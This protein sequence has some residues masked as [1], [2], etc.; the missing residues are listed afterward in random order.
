MQTTGG[1]LLAAK[2]FKAS[3]VSCGINTPQGERK[4]LVVVAADAPSSAAGVFTTNKVQAAP[5]VLSKAHVANGMAQAIVVNSGNAN[6][7]NGDAGIRDARAMVDAVADDLGI[8]SE[9]VLIAST[10]VIG[11]PMPMDCIQAGIQEATA[12]I[13]AGGGADAAE[14]IMTTDTVP[15]SHAIQADIEGYTV[16]IGGISKGAGMICPNMA[17]MIAVITTDAAIAPGVLKTALRTAVG[18]S[19][20]CISVDGDMSTNDTVFVLAN[21]AADNPMI[22]TADSTG[23]HPFEEALQKVCAVLARKIARD[24]EGATKFVE[25]QVNGAV[26]DEEARTIGMTVAN[27]LLVKTAIYGKDPNWGRIICAVGYADAASDPDR[28]DLFLGGHQLTKDGQGLPLDEPTM[29]GELETE[30]I[31]VRIELNMGEG[32]AKVWTCDM[33]HEYVTINAEY[34][35]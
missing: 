33:S 10:G 24:G 15:K 17:T 23:Y 14:A 28:I 29:R 8:A 27:S 13:N 32:A 34:T 21:G 30:D 3:T 20:N 25:I 6:A 19:F 22:T 16:T 31:Q 2:G 1:G 26:S 5:V 7:C 18:A 12:L 4:D 11:R 35:T 9:Q